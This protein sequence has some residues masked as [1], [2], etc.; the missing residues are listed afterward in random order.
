MWRSRRL[1]AFAPFG[2]VLDDPVGQR[3]LEPDIVARFLRL[4][5]LVLQNFLSLGLELAIERRIL[6]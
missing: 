5:P 4:N 3:L 6:Y 1:P 2:P